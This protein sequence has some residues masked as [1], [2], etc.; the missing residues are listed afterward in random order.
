MFGSLFSPMQLPQY[1]TDLKKER[2]LLT[3]HN[4]QLQRSHLLQKQKADRLEEEN[5]RL[6][7]KNRQLE[8]EKAKFI[9]ELEKTKAERDTYKN[10]ICKEKKEC[11]LPFSHK[12][13]GKKRGAQYGHTGISRTLPL[14]I[15]S[16]VRVSLTNCP[17]C[18]TPL[19]RVEGVSHHTV[20]DLPHWT[21]MQ[22]QT[23]QY[24]IERQWCG[25]CHKEVRGIPKSVIPG[26]R[27]GS[28]LVT[29]VLVWKYRFREPLNKIVERLATEYGIAVSVGGLQRILS[30]TKKWLGSRYKKL[31]NDIR[32][33]PV[34]HADETAWPVGADKWWAWVFVDPKTTVYTIEE[35]RGGGVA[36]AMLEEA[37]GIL[38]RD[39]Y[40]A[41]ICLS[42]LQ[43]SCW[44]H[45]LRKSH[46][47]AERV[48]ASE[49]VKKLHKELTMLFTLLAED[50]ATPFDKTE[51]EAWYKDYLQ[52]IKKII[53]CDYTHADTK[54]IQTRINNQGKNLL[55]ALL[56]PNVPLTNNL[57][58]R[59]I[60]PLVLTRKISRGSKTPKGAHIHA[61]N[62][63]IIETIAK[64]KHPLLE[65][66]HSYLLQGYTDKR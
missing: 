59:A 31:I 41:Y 44:A 4:Q 55:T 18:D 38:V 43:Q 63:S 61:V 33:S 23:T 22:P 46:E 64:R 24:Q 5:T 15:H 65:T 2:R 48:D 10:L 25:N 6:R 30:Q 62:M 37:L 57:A 36:K 14:H 32:G 39:D 51:R 20:T 58:E 42:L 17:A 13:T 19:A 1:V 26:S 27:L 47:A 16:V 7:Q 50:I 9:E 34:K 66:L 56:Y 11:S 54:R 49:E 21:K 12:P 35:S 60:M 28:V 52:D 8:K 29:M 40:S 53:V 3:I 45:L